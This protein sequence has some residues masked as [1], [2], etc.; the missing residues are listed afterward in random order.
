[1]P[2]RNAEN[3]SKQTSEIYHNICQPA[4]NLPISDDKNNKRLIP[5]KILQTAT[6]KCQIPHPASSINQH[7]HP[8]TAKGKSVR[9]IPS[10]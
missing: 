2:L 9:E 6:T 7:Q 10:I 5:I 4:R 3:S 8:E 1:L